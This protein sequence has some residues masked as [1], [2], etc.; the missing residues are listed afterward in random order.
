MKMNGCNLIARRWSGQGGQ[1]FRAY[2]PSLGKELEPAFHEATEEEIGCAAE[3]AVDAWNVGRVPAE[4]LA[5]AL[6]RIAGLILELD[7]ELLD[8]ASQETGLPLDRLAGERARTVGQLRLFAGLARDGS[9]CDA[10]IDQALPDRKPAP[11]P[12]LRRM[13]VPLGPIAV[14]AASNFPLAF[15]VAGGDTASALAAG[16]PVIVKA[17]PGHPG[18]SEMVAGAIARALEE[19]GLPPGMFSMIHGVAPE[20]SLLLVRHPAIRAGA[21]TGSLRAGRAL[22]DA[23]AE[24]PHSIPFFA[25][26]GSLNP[27]VVLPRALEQRGEEIAKGLF[28]SVTLGSGQFC[29]CPGVVFAVDAPGLENFRDVLRRQFMDARP[30]VMLTRAIQAGFATGACR[31]SE[32]NGVRTTT[33]TTH[34]AVDHTE[35]KPTLFEVSAETLEEHPELVE[36]LFGPSTVVVV[37]ESEGTLHRAIQGLPGSLTAT[38]HATDIDLESHREVV[39]VLQRKAGRLIFNGFPT[40]VEVSSAMQ[41]GGPYPATSDP[42]FTSVGTAAIQRFARPVCF[43]NF[44]DEALP[45]ELQ[46]SNPRRIS[47]MIEGEV[48]LA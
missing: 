8:R 12:D 34:S 31:V 10:R 39:T 43:Q 46:D 16:N 27:M 15:S 42:R 7:S 35:V 28:Q 4:Q 25:E 13:L 38:I 3:A 23:A 17:H 45:P 20:T 14:W 9:W 32:L 5:S 22:Y 41:H 1:C 6:E 18:T 48:K 36:E 40:G 21:F 26:M 2:A 33:A 37:C 29:T 24:R 30:A 11:R 19:T 47:R 44:P